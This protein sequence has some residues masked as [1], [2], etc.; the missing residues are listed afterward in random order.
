MNDYYLDGTKITQ[1]D[2]LDDI[3][4]LSDEDY[5]ELLKS[6]KGSTGKVLKDFVKQ[7][8]IKNISSLNKDDLVS[9]LEQYIDAYRKDDFELSKPYLITRD[10][11]ELEKIIKKNNIKIAYDLKKANKEDI[12]V[13]ILKFLKKKSVSP[14][15]YSQ[16]SSFELQR[17][18]NETLYVALKSSEDDDTLDDMKTIFEMSDKDFNGVLNLLKKELFGTVSK[19]MKK[20]NSED[21]I[22]K[23]LDKR[24]NI[25]INKEF[26]S[27]FIY[28]LKLKTALEDNNLRV[29]KTLENNKF[30]ETA[31]NNI[32]SQYIKIFKSFE[33]ED[34]DLIRKSLKEKFNK[35][36]SSE[37]VEYIAQYLSMPSLE[38]DEPLPVEEETEPLPAK[39]D[40]ETEALPDAEIAL[41]DEEIA[42]PDEEEPEILPAKKVYISPKRTI[43]EII[44][45][46][47]K[48]DDDEVLS[49]N[50][51]LGDCEEKI[52]YFDYCDVNNIVQTLKTGENKNEILKVLNVLSDITEW[53]DAVSEK[54]GLDINILINLVKQIK[55]P[56]ETK[57]SSKEVDTYDLDNFENIEDV[58]KE[59]Q[60]VSTQDI[61][62]STVEIT[63][64]IKKVLGIAVF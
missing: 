58:L 49:I 62:D 32:T 22:K 54:Y 10:K 64:K 30:Y 35:D 13:D 12:I 25:K 23:Q 43:D 19:L 39:A 15:F 7:F 46:L 57:Q 21:I 20:Y 44:V 29:L 28:E 16:S 24:K 48:I 40:E 5:D 59:I 42:L 55:E 1:L 45:A 47:E 17:D 56:K 4:A 2:D 33:T 18:N 51:Y 8:N 61:L 31:K 14:K 36:F 6:L 52:G 27:N 41:P 3:K 11:G 53:K 37:F 63:D 60:E 9:F 50:N 34:V 38:E 26:L